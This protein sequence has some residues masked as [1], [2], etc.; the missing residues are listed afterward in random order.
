M[1][2]LILTLAIAVSTF[3]A[4]AGEEN[5]TA[6]VLKSFN[7]EFAGAENVSWTTGRNSYKASFVMNGQHVVAY[8]SFEGEMLGMTRNISSLDLPMSLQ[9]GLKKDY[10]GYWISDLFEVSNQEGT[11]YYITLE[12]ADETLIL[13]AGNFSKWSVYQRASK[14]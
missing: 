12:K 8:Y 1:K 2:K 13:E 5:V 9:A 14:S 7:Q 4:F 10:K 11:T 3:A 6:V